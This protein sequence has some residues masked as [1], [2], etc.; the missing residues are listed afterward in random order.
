MS[1]FTVRKHAHDSTENKQQKQDPS[2]E[3]HEITPLSASTT[4]RVVGKRIS[5]LQ[6]WLL[7]P[8][9]ARFDEH[10]PNE[11]G[12]DKPRLLS[13]AEPAD[14][15]MPERSTN[16]PDKSQ[17]N[18]WTLS[19]FSF[20]ALHPSVSEAERREYERYVN[21]P[22]QIPLVTSQQS[23]VDYSKRDEFEDYLQ[24]AEGPGEANTNARQAEMEIWLRT[25]LI[26]DTL[27]VKNE[28]YEKK[29]Y[30]AYRK[31]LRGKSLFKQSKVDPEY[32]AG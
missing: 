22:L 23:S 25:G 15:P 29:R 17:Q 28:D 4:P 21:H 27:S 5:S 18:Q 32:R 13:L 1:P 20:N 6:Q 7:T 2:D 12:T 31:W 10:H 24:S 16:P 9:K 19:Q 3:T 8:P 11:R 26:E 14:T 30:Q